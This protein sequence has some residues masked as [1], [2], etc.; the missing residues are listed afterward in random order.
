MAV[1]TTVPSI[2][3]V[4]AS[5]TSG[6]LG[7]GDSINIQLHFDNIVQVVG[8]PQLALNF[9]SGANRADFAF[10]SGTNTLTFTYFVQA[11]DTVADLDLASATALILNGG[12]LI[13]PNTNEAARLTVPVGG[14]NS[15]LASNSQIV[16]DTVMPTVVFATN[17]NTSSSRQLT[18][19]VTGDEPIVCS[20]LSV[21]DGVDFVFTNIGSIA[22]TQASSR[23]C[24]IIATSLI[25][26]GDSG[27]SGLAAAQT[28]AVADANGLIAS[29]ITSPT[30]TVTLQ[31][32]SAG[33]SGSASG[34]TSSTMPAIPNFPKEAEALSTAGGESLALD[35]T[36]LD[37][38]K[39]VTAIQGTREIVV[40]VISSSATR[41]VFK[42][43]ALLAGSADL[44]IETAKGSVIFKNALNYV[45]SVGAGT[46]PSA[47][48]KSYV[49][50]GFAPGRA[51][52]TAVMKR[53]INAYVLANKGYRSISCAG[54]TMGPKRSAADLV[55]AKARAQAACS[56]ALVQNKSLKIAKLVGIRETKIGAQIRRILI[57][58]TK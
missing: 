4:D 25:A 53:A 12:T 3:S 8:T 5:V 2:T 50:S 49:I 9:G 48:K 7:V 33:G 1:V 39:R 43:P 18:F 57:S 6:L 26:A 30:L 58:L 46:P 13:N 20:S 51:V 15:S 35:G 28:F 41:L 17:S 22:I 45:E 27:T 23:V 44:I 21:V 54:Y 11:G 16:I 24:E 42:T 29:A 19:T 10:G 55:L 52:L 37:G 47:T 34:G 36:H 14:N 56:Y 38:V 31:P 40:E 32:A